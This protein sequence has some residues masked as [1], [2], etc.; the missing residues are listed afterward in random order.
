MGGGLGGASSNAAT[1]INFLLKV[2]GVR[3]SNE[4]FLK[5]TAFSLGADIPFFLVNKNSVVEGIGERVFPLKEKLAGIPV[6]LII[7]EGVSCSTKKMFKLWD[8]AKETE[9]GR[10]ML[11]ADSSLK[12]SCSW[13]VLINNIENDFLDIYLKENPYLTPIYEQIRREK[14]LII[15][16]SGTG[17]TFFVLSRRERGMSL[18]KLA[19]CVRERLK[20]IKGVKFK[21]VET[22]IL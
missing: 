21:L 10:D 19:S 4:E 16:L 15:S 9:R 13:E 7:P 18:N 2:K 11:V 5:E 3:S 20:G 14:E 6:I 22:F 17:S 1:V 8:L 12:D